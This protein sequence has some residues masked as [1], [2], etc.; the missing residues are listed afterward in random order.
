[1]YGTGCTTW[2]KYHGCV[3]HNRTVRTGDRD[4]RAERWQ[5]QRERRREEFVDA[6]LAA[7]ARYGPDVSTEQIA[8]TAG[9]ARTRIYRHFDGKADLQK[10]I[11]ARAVAQILKELEPVFRPKGTPLQ[12]TEVAVRT[13]VKWIADHPSIYRYVVDISG[14]AGKAFQ[15]AMAQVANYVVR[16]FRRYLEAYGLDTSGAVT[17]AHGLLGFIDAATRRWL[18][19]PGELDR[20]ALTQRLVSWSWLVISELF[21]GA[22]PPLHPNEPL[23][24]PDEVR[25]LRTTPRESGD[26][27]G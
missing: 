11:A 23:P 18:D 21:T 17:A 8:E 10:A 9:V 22:E 12:A 24:S 14:D 6:A 20:E 25:R 13:H 15:D 3:S 1:M 26:P 7:I 19:E 4:G 16:L 5:G 27:V 2:G